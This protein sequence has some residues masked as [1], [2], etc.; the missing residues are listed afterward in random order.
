MNKNK[1]NTKTVSE[2]KSGTIEHFLENSENINLCAFGKSDKQDNQPALC[3]DIIIK[4]RKENQNETSPPYK[5]AR[6]IILSTLD[7]EDNMKGTGILIDSLNR[8][9]NDSDHRNNSQKVVHSKKANITEMEFTDID[10]S[11]WE[12]TFELSKENLLELTEPQRC[13]VLEI[14]HLQSKILLTLI[15]LQNQ[16]KGLCYVEGLWMYTKFKVDS[17]LYM[18]AGIVEGKWVVNNKHGLIVLEPD[19]LIPS[20]TITSFLWCKRK[21]ILSERYRGFESTNQAMLVGSIVHSIIQE[22]M[23]NDINNTKELIEISKKHM[24]QKRVIK[25]LYECDITMETLEEEVNQYIPRIE[26]FLKT[27]IRPGFPKQSIKN[28]WKGRIDAIEDIEE[29]VW[30]PELGLKGKIDAMVTAEGRTMPVEIKTGRARVSLEH[31]GQILLYLA[32]IKNIGYNATSGLLLYLKEG[33]LK[34][35]PA[36]NHEQTDLIQ[37]RNEFIYYITNSSTVSND[38]FLPPVLPEPIDHHFCS[39]CSY[40]NICAAYSYYTNEDLTNRKHLKKIQQETLNYLNES[41]IEYFMKWSALLIMESQENEF[42]SSVKQAKDIFLIP[43]EEREVRGR[44]LTNLEVDLV[45]EESAEA[46]QHV[47]HKPN[48][49]SNFLNSGIYQ[50]NY[51]IVS[52]EKRYAVAC[53]FVSKISH[54]SIVVNL[55]KNLEQKYPNRKFT[56]DTYESG[57]LQTYQFSSLALLLENTP[58]A[59]NLRKTI[60]D[61]APPT[62]KPTLPK[63][64]ASKGKHILKTLNLV[65]QRAVLKAI[66][67][68]EYFLIKGMPGTGKTA[69]IVGLIQLLIELDKTVLITSHTHSAVDNVCLKLLKRGVKFMR[70]GAD[71]KIHKDVLQYSEHN[72]TKHCSTPEE[73]EAAYNS[74]RILAVT[75][76]ASGHPVLTKRSL[77]FCIVDESTQVLQSAIIRPLYS[78]KTFVLI[79]DPD[80]LPAVIKNNTAKELGMAESLFERLYRPDAAIALNINYRMNRTITSFANCLTYNGELKVANEAIENATIKANSLELRGEASWISKVLD[81]SIEEAVQFVDTGP[82]WNLPQNA[83]WKINK[84]YKTD[85]DGS[86]TLINIHEVGVIVR[87]VRALLAAGVDSVDVGVIATYRHQVEQLDAVLRPYSI[88]VNTVDQFQ[89]KDKG[90][91]IY[92]CGC[93]RDV[94]AFAAPGRHDLLEDKRRLNVAMTRAKHKLLVVGD[95]KTLMVFSTFKKLLERFE[96]K[97][98]RLA[99]YEDFSWERVLDVNS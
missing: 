19:I 22:A 24:Y 40:N 2:N 67:A 85:D 97:I 98:V 81:G 63:I 80:Q 13:K 50:S 95:V 47:F 11:D 5:K 93:S 1:L 59:D 16:H 65:Q 91:I 72:L 48:A 9:L 51:V 18:T 82:V 54:D 32:M 71:S 58:K 73:Y 6:G 37:L 78:C 38:K 66:T 4:K 36:S 88:D 43:P 10:F 70:L 90:V 79:G 68:N 99:D 39:N 15:S 62:F 92:S 83:A 61:K 52:T 34:E 46:V 14:S 53:G 8:N 3:A 28:N 76:Y 56:I 7:K 41:H 84:R 42:K 96:D 17:I 57:R 89:G 31:R 12:D 45:I 55:D 23:K 33:I 60:I 27:Y 44:C 69:T 21:S 64:I 77:D 87:I 26:D 74:A 20:T 86:K 30:C 25:C 94:A 35:I 75:C 29:N 49:N